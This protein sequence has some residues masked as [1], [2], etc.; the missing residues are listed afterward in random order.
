MD[1]FLGAHRTKSSKL[2]PKGIELNFT[3]VRINEKLDQIKCGTFAPL[4]SELV[5]LRGHNWKPLWDS[6]EQMNARL[7]EEG[8]GDEGVRNA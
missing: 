5:T 6:L 3:E 4:Q 1:I 2:C 7:E 8:V